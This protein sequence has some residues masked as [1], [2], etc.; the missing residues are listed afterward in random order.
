MSTC[1]H[2]GDRLYDKEEIEDLRMERDLAIGYTLDAQER[3]EELDTLR[4]DNSFLLKQGRGLSFLLEQLKGDIEVRDQLI[5][6]ARDYVI[7]SRNVASMA[8]NAE[9][10]F[11]AGCAHEWLK[12]AQG[13]VGEK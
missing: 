7:H 2:C 1:F 8:D 11:F 4:N 5:R 12:K 13:I 6:E 9:D 3:L 10:D